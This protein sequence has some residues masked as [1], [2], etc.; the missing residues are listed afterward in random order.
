MLHGRE[1]EQDRDQ[2]GHR[3][4]EHGQRAVRAG[5]QQPGEQRGH[6]VRG[7]HGERAEAQPGAVGRVVAQGEQGVLADLRRAERGQHRPRAAPAFGQGR[8][9]E[10]D[11]N[12]QRQR[13]RELGQR[14][15]GRPMRGHAQCS[16]CHGQ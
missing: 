1:R 15:P 3:R 11:Q 8:A 10:R 9:R 5:Q 6:R 12:C 14:A 7:G 2:A 13:G 16:R 4:G